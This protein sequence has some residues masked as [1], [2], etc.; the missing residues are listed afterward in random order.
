MMVKKTQVVNYNARRYGKGDEDVSTRYEVMTETAALE[1]RKK[2]RIVGEK[3][4][5][6]TGMMENGVTRT[7]E[8]MQKDN[9]N[10]GSRYS[11]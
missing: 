6:R 1:A 5:K 2:Y 9:D 3:T 10:N 7:A 11:G 8:E 4:G